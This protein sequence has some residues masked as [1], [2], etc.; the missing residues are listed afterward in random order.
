MQ[1]LEEVGLEPLAQARPE[2]RFAWHQRQRGDL[3]L[4]GTPSPMRRGNSLQQGKE[5]PAMFLES[6][7]GSEPD[8]SSSEGAERGAQTPQHQ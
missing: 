1:P 7:R 3:P 8:P 6:A 2:G 5:Q 4:A